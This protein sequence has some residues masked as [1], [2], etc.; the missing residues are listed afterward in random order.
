[1]RPGEREALVRLDGILDYLNRA[2]IQVPSPR[3]WCLPLDVPL[4]ADLT[5]PLFVRTAQTSWKR[6]GHF[7]RVKSV[8]EL[9][10][11][12]AALRRALGWDALILAREWV[13]LAP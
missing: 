10:A 6:G 7:S 1:D 8:R 12:A 5:F 9:E 3:T 2:G 11:E 4:P 13:E